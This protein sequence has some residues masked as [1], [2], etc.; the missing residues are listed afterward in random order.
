MM[1]DL[2]NDE[3]EIITNLLQKYIPH[4][5]IWAFGSRVNGNAKRYSDLDLAIID[6]QSID[7]H[8]IIALKEALSESKLDIKVDLLEWSKLNESFQKIILK[9]YIFHQFYFF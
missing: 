8:L 2:P 9:N 5:E 4:A 6:S 3:L 7:I 1:I